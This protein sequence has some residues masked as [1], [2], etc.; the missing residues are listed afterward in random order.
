[1]R[2]F[3]Q[4]QNQPQERVSPSLARSNTA[5]SGPI[6]HT[7]PILHLQRT[8]GNQ[9][10]QRL[11]RAKSGDLNAGNS[12]VNPAPPI[13]Q[14]VL[15][16]PGQPLG[17]AVRNFMEPRLGHDFSQ[18]R[19]HA[20]SRAAES[21]QALGAK[22]YT[23]G[24]DIVFGADRLDPQSREGRRLIAHELVHTIQQSRGGPAPEADSDASH[25]QSADRVANVIAGGSAV[26]TIPGAT[27][28]GIAGDWSPL[29]KPKSDYDSIEGL[30]TLKE[31]FPKDAFIDQLIQ[32]ESRVYA[33][34]APYGFQGSWE[35]DEDYLPDFDAAIERWREQVKE[36]ERIADFPTHDHKGAFFF[37]NGFFQARYS[38]SKGTLTVTVPVHFTFEDSKPQQSVTATTGSDPNASAKVWAG[39]EIEEWRKKFIQV[40]EQTWSNKHTLYCYEDGLKHLKANVIVK[41]DDVGKDIPGGKQLF[42]IKVYRGDYAPGK[43]SR[44]SSGIVVLAYMDI[45]DD[46]AAHEF[47]HMLGLGDEYEL[48]GESAEAA[49]SQLVEREFGYPV[50]RMPAGREDQFRESI[51]YSSEEGEVLPEHG[52][53]FLEAMRKIT[54]IPYWSLKP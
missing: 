8:I 54:R 44:V 22:A 16:S 5:T 19:V 17:P 25:E 28:V 32:N 9:A 15:A 53:I 41:V 3:A 40:A 36:E 10:M 23:V 48:P 35:R 46:T 12:G 1:M 49:H 7:H 11:L 33:L 31:F 21:A 14:K 39:R 51:M 50:P 43:G 38:P 45:Q 2:N 30:R 20:T 4:K 6:H 52:V 18:V 37:H 47:G 42:K 27:A 34:L 29:S 24:Q 26:E 13:V